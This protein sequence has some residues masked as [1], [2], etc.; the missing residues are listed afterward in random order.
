MEVQL[1]TPKQWNCYRN[2]LADFAV[3]YS[4]KRLTA[5][6]I[7]AFRALNSAQLVPSVDAANSEA[8]VSIARQ[9][10]RLLG[11][12][13]AINGSK[14]ECFFVVHPEARELGV[15]TTVARS[16]ISRLGQL[17]C[18]VA[19]DNIPSMALCFRL[20]MSAVSMFTG[21]TGKPTLRFERRTSNDAACTRNI[22][23]I[24]Q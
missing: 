5:A 20:G 13:F 15:G 21:P 14:Q 4:D 2:R 8:A 23:A 16:L 24:P 3:Q 11:V 10:S 6:S 19:V 17:T 7:Q 18:H 9:G 12:G 1:L 22:D